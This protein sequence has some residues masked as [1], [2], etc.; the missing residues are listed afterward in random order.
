MTIRSG[1]EKLEVMLKDWRIIVKPY[2]L[3]SGRSVAIQ[4]LNTFVPFA[5]ICALMYYSLEWSYLATLGLSV[6]NGLFL[7]RIFVIQH[8]CGHQSFTGSR[9]LNVAIGTF[10]SLFTIIPF[11]NWKRVHN[12]HHAHNGKME[13][14]G[15]GDIN[16]LTTEEYGGLSR[17][18][19]IQYRVVRLN[20][21]QF[22]I[23]PVI[24]IAVIQQFPYADITKKRRL[25]VW[26][27]INQLLIVSIYCVFGL[28]VGWQKVA[29]VQVPI[30][31]VFGIVAFW[32]FYVQHQHEENYNEWRDNWDHLPASILG[33]SYY[34]L[35]KWA[36]WFSGDIGYH[37][38]HHLSPR[39][40]NYRLEEC[41]KEN[42]VFSEFVRTL[43]FRQSLKCVGHR[44]WDE[45]EK[46]MITFE[47]YLKG[48][49][50]V[51]Q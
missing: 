13:Y 18:G 42:P 46:R 32:L 2:Q 30:V 23:I 38:I 14:R 37:H 48:Q 26:H 9:R 7:L 27:F 10:S 6:V 11:S 34:Q 24:Y 5:G 4:L 3:P 45:K 39:I 35:P 8:D 21:M 49:A 36:R 19:K 25:F 33:S 12:A 31:I 51:R 43:D 22:L 1:S 41:F 47:E 44:L 50:S 16:F 29:M 17:M 40:P 20:V 15:L 28:L